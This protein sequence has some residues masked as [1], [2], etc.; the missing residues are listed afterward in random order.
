MT[1]VNVL[2]DLCSVSDVH[3][4]HEWQ[5][6]ATDCHLK[7]FRV[8]AYFKSQGLNDINLIWYLAT[9]DHM[10]LLA[11]PT[12]LATWLYRTLISLMILVRVWSWQALAWCRAVYRGS[13]LRLGALTRGMESSSQAT[14]LK[15]HWLRWEEKEREEGGEGRRERERERGRSVRPSTNFSQV[16]NIMPL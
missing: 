6:Q 14:V 8:Q 12:L 5:N 16:H 9:T 11:P 10:T 7:S 4:C 15:E 2:S 3:W 1:N 13:C